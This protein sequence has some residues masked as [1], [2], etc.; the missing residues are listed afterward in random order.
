MKILVSFGTL[1]GNAE[2]VAAHVYQYFTDS[3]HEVDILDQAFVSCADLNTYELHIFVVSTWS[4]GSP[5]PS[6]DT[7]QQEMRTCNTLTSTHFVLIGLGDSAYDETF[8][9]AAETLRSELRQKAATEVSEPL[10]LDGPPEEENLEK[11][12][13]YLKAL[14][15]LT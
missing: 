6:T 9:M 10:L 15:V 5:P 8:C 11:V 13:Q 3:G 1:T 14:K 12:S 2:L 4:D 7:L